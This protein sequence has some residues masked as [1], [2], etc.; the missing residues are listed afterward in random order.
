MPEYNPEKLKKWCEEE[1]SIK[2][3]ACGESDKLYYKDLDQAVQI[4]FVRGWRADDL[5]CYCIDCT[6]K[7]LK[8]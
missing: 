8:L 7:H 5:S 4:F 3:T 2:C 1:I 6:K